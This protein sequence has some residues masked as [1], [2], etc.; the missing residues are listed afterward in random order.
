MADSWDDDDFEAPVL[1]PQINV[2]TSWEDE[3]EVET[4]IVVVAKP[5]LATLEAK[6][7]KA[8]QDE[9][10][11]QTRL[12]LAELENETSDEKRIRERNQQEEADAHLTNELFDNITD[13]KA[14]LTNNGTGIGSMV[15]KTKDDHKNFA[16]MISKKLHNSS[17]Y[18]V[19]SFYKSLG[20]TLNGPGINSKILDEII[21]EISS[22]RDKKLK[23]EVAA[24]PVVQKKSKKQIK[25]EQEKH[26]EIFG[27]ASHV[28]KYDD[29]Y[30]DYEDGFM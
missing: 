18:H 8:A 21:G 23:S 25:K 22:I 9:K 19:V 5:S 1:T 3:D 15:L 27:G 24:A 6:K 11:F 26:N 17:A 28:D 2:P 4:N 14:G 20:E 12:Q 7:K 29:Q 10:V 30:G 16:K 13:P